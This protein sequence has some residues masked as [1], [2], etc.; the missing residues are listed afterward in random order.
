MRICNSVPRPSHHHVAS[1]VVDAS[2]SPAGTNTA[3]SGLAWTH[4]LVSEDPSA[5]QEKAVGG[6]AAGPGSAVVGKADVSNLAQSRRSVGSLADSVLESAAVGAATTP[7]PSDRRARTDAVRLPAGDSHC[8]PHVWLSVVC[9]DACTAVPSVPSRRRFTF[10]NARM[11][12]FYRSCCGVS[13]SGASTEFAMPGVSFVSRKI[14]LCDRDGCE[15][16][17]PWRT[18]FKLSLR[19][20]T[21]K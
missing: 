4:D 3:A 18:R 17:R 7:G 12:C 21:A 8:L 13:E 11:L 10:S 1:A 16:R 19:P 14:L 9:D 15:Q 20:T 6:A 2:L 5:A